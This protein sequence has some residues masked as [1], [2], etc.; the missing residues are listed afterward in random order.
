MALEPRLIQDSFALLDGDADRVASHFYALLFLEDPSLRD[1]FPP[2]MDSHRDR[3]ISALVKVVHQFDE[4]AAMQEYLSQLGR[5]HRKYGVR[6]E[7]YQI[8]WRCLLSTLKRFARPGWTPEMDAAWAAA[9]QVIADTMIDAAA[10]A[11]MTTP[12]WWQGRV[13]GHERKTSSLAVITLLPD[14]PFSYRAGQYVAVETLRWPRVWRPYSIANAPRSDGTI[15]LHVRAIDGGWV[16]SALV[17]HTLVGDVV[18]LGPAIGSLTVEPEGERN[19]LLIGGGTGIA[20]LLAIAQ[21]MGRWNTSRRVSVFFGA[22]HVEELYVKDELDELVERL[23]WLNV[24]YCVSDDSRYRGDRGLLPQVV[25][26][27]GA[28]ADNWRGHEVLVAGSAAMTRA[29]LSQLLGGG[30]PLA[31]IRFDAFSDQSTIFLEAKRQQQDA[32][33]L[34][35]AARSARMALPPG[36]YSPGPYPPGSYPPSSY[37]PGP[38]QLGSGGVLDPDQLSKSTASTSEVGSDW[39]VRMNPAARSA[40]SSA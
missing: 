13:V 23:P 27:D 15:T 29:T 2:M 28:A 1:L 40:G 7:H 17:H 3:L 25:A 32:D 36:P 21:D 18:R 8:F 22:R 11:A 12:A 26:R 35:L 5:D 30:V 20:P 9:F 6:A 34:A 33:R 14:S 37:P 10:Q 38:C 19:V 24:V 31:Q 4:P 39:Q 16:S